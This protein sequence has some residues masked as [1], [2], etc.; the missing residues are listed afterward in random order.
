MA[1]MLRVKIL[2]AISCGCLWPS[3]LVAQT[4]AVPAAETIYVGGPILTMRGSAPEFVESLA[5]HQGKI[6]YAG[7]KLGAKV[8]YG[9]ATQEIDLAGKTLLPG[10][11]DSHSH[12]LSYA[13]SL[14]QANLSPPP[15]G[16]VTSIAGILEELKQLQAKL[17]LSDRQWL[18]GSGYDQDFL[19]E[20]RH[21][22]AEDLDVLF[23]AQPVVL[24]HASGH[25][26]V[27]NSAAL[28]AAGI[29]AKTVDPPGGTILRRPGTSEPEGLVQEMAMSAFLPLLNA[30]RPVD[31]DL[32]LI[33]RAVQHY[34]SY[35]VTTAA[36]H[37]LLPEKFTL[38]ESAARQGRLTID[39]VAAPIY[40]MAPQLVGSGKVAWGQ[41][42][43]RLKYGGLKV[44]VDGS[45]QG[46]TAFLTKPYLT[47]VPGCSED[48]RGFPNIN[49]EALN[50]LLELSY[51]NR[52]Q[53]FAHCNGDAA[54]DMLITAHRHAAATLNVDA[55]SQRTVVIHSQITRPDQL[56]TYRELGLLPSFFTNHVFY[57]G[58][59]HRENLGVERASFISPLHSALQQGIIASNHTDSTVTPIDPLALLWSAVARTTRSGQIL[60][61]AER[62]SVYD[63]L[64]AMTSNAAYQYFEEASKGTLEPGK[65]A[66]LVILDR[67]PLAVEPTELREIRVVETIKDGESVYRRP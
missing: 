20:K 63:G 56:A 26:L 11:I 30:P 60:G 62:V 4:T 31:V 29:D 44:S 8:F 58:D 48:C 12:L 2:V 35:G 50:Q 18:V 21:P 7:S 34:A 22:T 6:V 42:Q 24:V 1:F 14:L 49:Q 9:P 23:P 27:A 36:E 46:K 37:L 15:V 3:W 10:F 53:L 45:P 17:Q 19:A 47:P 13:E 38:L 43:G 32:E 28:K 40:L 16:K 52:I 66:D 59:V 57:W 5:V 54:I 33:Q 25:M 55:L 64:R 61:A 39:M 41:Y 51:K 67:N 65:R